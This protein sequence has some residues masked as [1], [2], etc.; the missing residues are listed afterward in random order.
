MRDQAIRYV[1]PWPAPDVGSC[2]FY[3]SMDIPGTGTVHGQWDMRGKFTEYIG[4]I[5]VTGRTLLDVGTSSGFLLF[6]AEKHGAAVTGFDAE[7]WTQYQVVPG[8][9]NSHLKDGFFQ[10]QNGFWLAHH[11]F[12][13]RAKVIYGDIY[14]MSEIVP[15]HDIVVV[16]Q[17]LVHLRDPLGALF[18]ASLVADDYLIITEGSFASPTPAALFLGRDGNEMTWWHLSDTIYRQWLSLLG[19]DILSASKTKYK[20]NAP[21]MPSEVELWTFVSKRL[22]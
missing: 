18:Q 10:M 19:F 5:D 17:I 1:E 8:R 14:R 16:G 11:A 7:S 3:H 20:C 13:S 21:G 2:W 12:N 15:K 9:A 4:G 22:E 6:E